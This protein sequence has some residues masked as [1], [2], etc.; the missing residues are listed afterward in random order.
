[1]VSIQ[2]S[3]PRYAVG[4]LAAVLMAVTGCASHRAADEAAAKPEAAAPAPAPDAASNQSDDLT[5]TDAALQNVPSNSAAP[6][7]SS[8]IINPTAPKSYTV[9]R[10]DTLWAIASMFLKDP[11]LWPEVWYINPQVANPHLIYPGDTL[12]LAAGSDGRPQIRL[13]Q[14]GPARLDPRLR[15]SPI[16][17]AIP[18]IPYSAI[19]AFL[20]RPTVLTDEQIRKAPYV[21]A[22]REEHVIGGMGHEIYVQHLKGGTNGAG[23]LNVWATNDSSVF[24]INVNLDT[25]ADNTYQGCQ[26][27][28][29]LVWY[30]AQ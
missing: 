1:M 14:G 15:S 6:V 2:V 29:D 17:G 20:S 5:A 16:D 21:L 8:S 25:S 10:G 28:A 22:F 23:A 11:W 24:T 9:K 27:Q 3:G 30:G 19:A 26:S 13:E 18:T 7:V 4:L 12:A